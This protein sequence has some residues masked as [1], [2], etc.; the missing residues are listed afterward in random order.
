MSTGKL[1]GRCQNEHEDSVENKK[2]K[3]RE[4]L[5]DL[6]VTAHCN[7]RNY[8]QC[9]TDLTDYTLTTVLISGGSLCYNVEATLAKA[10]ASWNLN[11]TLECEGINRDRK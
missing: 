1:Q 5:H 8:L 3:T 2:N 6:N 9:V 10:H 7:T 4:L 11:L